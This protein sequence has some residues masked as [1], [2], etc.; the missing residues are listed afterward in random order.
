MSPSARGSG[1]ARAPPRDGGTHGRGT[2]TGRSRTRCAGTRSSSP[3]L[4]WTPPPFSFQQSVPQPRTPPSAPLLTSGVAKS[5]HHLGPSPTQPV[6]AS[7]SSS[8]SRPSA[9]DSR[10]RLCNPCLSIHRKKRE[11][12]MAQSRICTCTRNTWTSDLWNLSYR[13]L[14]PHTP[15]PHPPL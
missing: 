15:P 1:L 2:T 9:E 5:L 13:E 8:C 6:A 10:Y 7:S 3:R 4:T 12:L 11:F 14:S